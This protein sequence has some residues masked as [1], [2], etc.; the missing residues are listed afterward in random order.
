MSVV[1]FINVSL[2]TGLHSIKHRKGET[3]LIINKVCMYK[4]KLHQ[5]TMSNTLPL[6]ELSEF[7]SAFGT[8]C[9]LQVQKTLLNA[10][11]GPQ[12]CNLQTGPVSRGEKAMTEL[13]VYVPSQTEI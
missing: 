4:Y 8:V 5:T 12:Q 10:E 3:T 1:I 7:N 9:A 11:R 2:Y 13:N 6:L